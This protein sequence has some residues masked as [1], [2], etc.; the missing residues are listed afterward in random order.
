[1]NSGFDDLLNNFNL[2]EERRVKLSCSSKI[3]SIQGFISSADP[4]QTH[5]IYG[6]IS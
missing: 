3:S 5:R 4:Y 6:W 1:M 2:S